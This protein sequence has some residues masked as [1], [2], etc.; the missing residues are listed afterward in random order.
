M[1]SPGDMS[2]GEV[3]FNVVQFRSVSIGV[4]K[5]EDQRLGV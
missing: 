4:V 1:P 3:S 5:A 2:P